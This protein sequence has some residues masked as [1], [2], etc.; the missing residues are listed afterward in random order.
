MNFWIL[1]SWYDVDN[2]WCD[3]LFMVQNRMSRQKFCYFWR[4]RNFR[5]PKNF[6]SFF[7]A[8]LLWALIWIKLRKNNFSPLDFRWKAI[9]TNTNLKKI[10]SF[11]CCYRKKYLNVKNLFFY[12]FF[13]FSTSG[14]HQHTSRFEISFGCSW[15]PFTLHYNCKLKRSYIVSSF[16]KK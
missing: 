10:Y 11:F 2:L 14:Y 4:D 15:I 1:K 12:I 8:G 5:S 7:L 6:F 9:N 16:N 13:N 3:V